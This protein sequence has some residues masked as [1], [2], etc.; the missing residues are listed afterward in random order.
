MKECV[1]SG[2]VFAERGGC[3][4]ELGAHQAWE[5]TVSAHEPSNYLPISQQFVK[6]VQS[7]VIV[8]FDRKIV[9]FHVINV[10]KMH[11]SI[12]NTIDSYMLPDII[13][14]LH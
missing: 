11:P 1:G 14:S 4:G 5:K 8:K 6:N 13:I 9:E 12:R 10:S 2:R 3:S 7:F